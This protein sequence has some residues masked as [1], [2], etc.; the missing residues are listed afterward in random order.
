VIG[1][2]MVLRRISRRFLYQRSTAT[3]LAI[4]ALFWS[5]LILL[6]AG[7]LLAR[8][9]R[10]TSERNF[11]ERLLLVAL[12]LAADLASQGENE[13]LD[14]LREGVSISD[15]RFSLPLS[16][17]YWQILRL[18]L[19]YPP[20]LAGQVGNSRRYVSPSLLAAELPLLGPDEQQSVRS[21]VAVARA[22]YKLGPEGNRL[23]LVE[24]DIDLGNETRYRISVA[25]QRAFVLALTL[26]FLL[27]GLALALSTL[28]QIR[29]GLAPLLRLQRAIGAIR[30]GERERIGDSFPKDLAPL[31]TEINL[32]LD[33]NAAI[34][35]RAR[36]QAGNLAHALK[37]PLT[38]ILNEA[39]EVPPPFDAKLRE[40]ALLMRERIDLS[41]ARA[42]AGAVAGE[43]SAAILIAPILDSLLNAFRKIYADRALNFTVEGDTSLRFRGERQDLEEM[44]GCLIDN[45]C[46]WA[47][48]E[49]R[50]ILSAP[51]QERDIQTVLCLTIQDDGPGMPDALLQE[52]PVRGRRLD[53]TKPGTG[54][55]LS[56]V[57][58]LAPLYGGTLTLHRPQQGGLAAQLQ[59]VR[60][61]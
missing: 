19:S 6:V 61:A 52:A 34:L 1:Q 22:G 26:T 36:I 28:L 40:Q 55:G 24:R 39:Q 15:P 49:I 2:D 20:S 44:L 43:L 50:I 57:A 21:P 33:A 18:P 14:G 7:L 41:L 45:A 51:S 32:L 25:E 29:F 60:K 58:D 42:R 38:V 46:K 48:S 59:F 47:N 35:E 10:L 3:R 11:D 54:L 31:A 17:W 4:S 8:L 5:F 16:G 9:H 13:R 37:T 12:D 30:R 56:I 53:E 27:L 23:R